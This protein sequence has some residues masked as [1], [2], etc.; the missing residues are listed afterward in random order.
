MADKLV[1]LIEKLDS[2]TKEHTTFSGTNGNNGSGRH[3]DLKPNQAMTSSG[4]IVNLQGYLNSTAT[5][6]HLFSF[7]PLV[8]G[9]YQSLTLDLA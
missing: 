3:S 5:D 9:G 8:H 4:L 7:E 1:D 6:I 2:L